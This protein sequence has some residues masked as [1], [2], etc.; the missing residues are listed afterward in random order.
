MVGERICPDC[1][2]GR[3]ACQWC[4]N[5]TFRDWEAIC[6]C[7]LAHFGVHILP[8]EERAEFKYVIAADYDTAELPR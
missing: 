7:G 5:E 3:E 4:E 6:D 1:Q 2:R 8:C